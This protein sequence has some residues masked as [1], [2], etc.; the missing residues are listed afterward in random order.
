MFNI[1]NFWKSKQTSSSVIGGAPDTFIS[2]NITLDV[3]ALTIKGSDSIRI[4]GSI[5]GD[6]NITNTFIVG[7]SGQVIGDIVCTEAIIAGYVSGNIT[8]N[9][10]IHITPTGR[11]CGKVCANSATIDEG[12][13]MNG[14]YEIG[15][16]PKEFKFTPRT[17]KSTGLLI[18]ECQS[19]LEKSDNYIKM[20]K[21]IVK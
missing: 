4:D 14:R 7:E 11:V 12:A 19:I 9:G 20:N 17:K 15:G 8:C 10:S 3:D 18:T 13:S 5:G 6:I 2:E 16:D 21:T 1:L